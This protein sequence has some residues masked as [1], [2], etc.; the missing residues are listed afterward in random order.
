MPARRADAERRLRQ[1]IKELQ[2]HRFGRRAETLP[3]DQML[4]GLKELAQSEASE[5]AAKPMTPAEWSA[6][7]ERRRRTSVGKLMSLGCRSVD[8]DPLEITGSQPAWW[9]PIRIIVNRLHRN[10]PAE[11]HLT[12]PFLCQC[13]IRPSLSFVQVLPP[14]S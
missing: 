7:A 3:E 6:R 10:F 14:V 4:L 12:F 1:I 13:Q 11:T 2:R 5:D 9:T 8:R